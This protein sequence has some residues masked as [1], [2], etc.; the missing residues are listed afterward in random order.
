[1]SSCLPACVISLVLTLFPNVW[2][3]RLHRKS[4]CND[5][6]STSMRWPRRLER[7]ASSASAPRLPCRPFPVVIGS[8]VASASSRRSKWPS[9]KGC[10]LSSVSCVEPRSSDSTS[11]AA[12]LL[13]LLRRRL[14]QAPPIAAHFAAAIW[15][16]KAEQ[17]AAVEVARSADIPGNAGQT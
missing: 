14:R 12:R 7:S 6:R 9:V 1:M 13:S 3:W 16:A 2:R 11:L 4:C 17:A 15:L 5:W 8:S 10:F